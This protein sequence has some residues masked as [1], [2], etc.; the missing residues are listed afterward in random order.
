M[1][2]RKGGKKFHDILAAVVAINRDAVEFR[3]IIP[4][5]SNEG[6]WGSSWGSKLC[7]GTNIF[8][9]IKHNENEFFD[10]FVGLK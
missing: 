6:K 3:E 10:T 2:K 9:S 1:K 8:I 7:S 4:C 5:R